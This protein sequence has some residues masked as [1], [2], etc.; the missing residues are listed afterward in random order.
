MVLSVLVCEPFFMS[1]ILILLVRGGLSV[2]QCPPLASE[3]DFGPVWK[4]MVESNPNPS[5]SHDKVRPD[6]KKEEKKERRTD[7][8]A[9]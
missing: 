1:A 9:V 6:K 5:P 7:V 2:R 8:P 3:L 4:L